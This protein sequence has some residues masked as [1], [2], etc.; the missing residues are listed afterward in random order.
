MRRLT[1]LVPLIIVILFLSAVSA[2]ATAT[3]TAEQHPVGGSGIHGLIHFTDNG[4][5]LTVDGSATGLTPRVP[6]FSLIYTLG[7]DPGGVSENKSPRPGNSLPACDDLNRAGASTV[8]PTQMAVGFW[9]NHND[10]TG[11]LHV[12]KSTH[13]NS[14]EPLWISLGLQSAF[15]SFGVVFGGNSYSPIG[16]WRTISI[17]DAANNFA[18]VA[19]G[20]VH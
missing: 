1:T 14:Q 20:E 8:T 4:S 16:M 19:C 2:G 15:E 3:A 7:S 9:L 6:Y 10:G 11:T 13:G 12:V 18:L 17:R 5:T